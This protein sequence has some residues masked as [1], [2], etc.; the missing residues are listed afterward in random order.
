MDFVERLFWTLAIFFGVHF[1]WLAWL[2]DDFPLP[3]GTTVAA[4]LSVGFF[5][6][7][8]RFMPYEEKE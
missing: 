1:V 2:E 4:V 5:V 7:A 8:W 3:I 6:L